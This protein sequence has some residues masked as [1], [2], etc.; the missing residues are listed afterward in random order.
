MILNQDSERENKFIPKKIEIAGMEFAIHPFSAI[1]A[2]KLKATLLKKLAPAAGHLFGSI[3]NIEKGKNLL[4]NKINGDSIAQ[5]LESLFLELG[6]EEFLSLIKRFLKNTIAVIPTKGTIQLNTE[7]GI[8]K[9]FQ[10]KIF[11]IY[12]LI[13][14]VLK[15]NYPDFFLMVGGFGNQ[16]K[17]FIGK[18]TNENI[19]PTLKK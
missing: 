7:Q 10:G 9:I 12:P 13:F 5:A 14:E 6:E 15:V 2:L 18:Y 8:N 11:S 16:L 3:D 17:T 1:E 4:D 19:E